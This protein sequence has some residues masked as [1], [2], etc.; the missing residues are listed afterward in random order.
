MLLLPEILQKI[1][2]K[3]PGNNPYSLPKECM[4]KLAELYEIGT[5]SKKKKVTAER[6][7]QILIDN[8]FM[9]QWDAIVDITVPKIKAFFSLPRAK[10]KASVDTFCID[11]DI[12]DE[13]T[14]AIVDIETLDD[15]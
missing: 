1:G 14:Q 9:D 5:T 7:H 8:Y 10:M 11:S 2:Q 13:A 6:A 3:Y 15:E 12:V 4:H